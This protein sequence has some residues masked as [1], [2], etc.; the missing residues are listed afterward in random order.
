MHFATVGTSWITSAFIDAARLSGKLTLEAVYSRSKEK[1]EKM[2]AKHD[3]PQ[4]FTDL[5][6]MAKD[7]KID[8][9]YLASPNSLHF[10][11]VLVFLKNKKHVICE[12][13]IFSNTE[14]FKKAFQI[15]EENGVFLFE[16]IRNIHYPNAKLLKEKL[17]DAGQIRSAIFQYVQYSSR[18]DAFLAGEEPNVFSRNFSGGALMDLGVYPLSL[19]IY[20]F[21]A[22]KN[23]HYF[24]VLLRNGIDGAGTLVLEYEGFNIT[25]ICSKI[26]HSFIPSEI[27]GE[28]GSIII[29]GISELQNMKF[30]DVRT[31][32]PVLFS[33][34]QVEQNMMYEIIDFAD[35]I[36]KKDRKAYEAL[37]QSSFEV[38]S[39]IE[40]SRKQNGIV[41]K[42][43]RS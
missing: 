24:P 3:A 19:A 31:K 26:S 43:D 22:P 21:G 32:E 1:A 11:Q 10:E 12:K 6:E 34:E 29:E 15:A 25:V 42:T 37:K 36:A 13:P 38:L 20:L 28:K 8:A 14:E 39:V 9:V 18:Y 17:K 30:A 16:A 35:I 40:K 2:A 41:F 23:S 5:E 7:E 33:G 27:H 4:I